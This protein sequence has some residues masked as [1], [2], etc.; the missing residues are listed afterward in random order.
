ME[1]ACFPPVSGYIPF[2]NCVTVSKNTT[3]EIEIS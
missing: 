2:F 3:A 1:N